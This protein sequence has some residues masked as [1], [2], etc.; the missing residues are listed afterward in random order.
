MFLHKLCKLNCCSYLA[1][2]N[3]SAEIVLILQD[4]WKSEGGMGKGRARR[5]CV[6][7]FAGL[8]AL[9]CLGICVGRSLRGLTA[10]CVAVS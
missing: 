8:V 10:G 5:I 4:A 1:N 7:V 3:N 6:Y 9:G 2:N